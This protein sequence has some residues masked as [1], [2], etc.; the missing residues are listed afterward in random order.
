MKK[1][2]WEIWFQ[3]MGGD[4]K[5][6][7]LGSGQY[8][9]QEEGSRK[10][11]RWIEQKEGYGIRNQI[12][13][14]GEYDKQ[15]KKIG[16]WD[17][18][19][20]QYSNFTLCGCINYNSQGVEI[21]NSE[22]SLKNKK[23]PIIYVGSFKNEKKNGRWDIMFKTGSKYEQIGGGQY[24]EYKDTTVKVGQWIDIGNEYEICSQ[25]TYKGEY[26]MKGQKIGQWDAFYNWKN[27]NKKIGGGLYE[28]WEE[29]SRKIGSWIELDERFE[30]GNEITYNGEYNK[31]GKKVGTWVEVDLGRDPTQQIIYEN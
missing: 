16:R 19:E 9:E 18:L 11:G 24:D 20:K 7:Q 27:E 6:E 30:L 26:N 13:Y 3:N 31:D 1:G 8:D 29:S 17:I 2:T 28:E 12:I 5:K 22:N 23:N 14:S 4:Y 10:I 21:Y 25:I 15:E